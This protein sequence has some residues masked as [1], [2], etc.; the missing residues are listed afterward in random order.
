MAIGPCG[1][2]AGGSAS[3]VEERR[4]H[5]DDAGLIGG[6]IFFGGDDLF[7]CAAEMDSGGEGT[8]FCSPWN[9]GVERVVD[10]EGAAAVTK[11]LEPPPI[12]W[13][14]FVGGNGNQLARGDVGQ[15]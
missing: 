2:M 15:D 1:V 8:V 13:R 6:E 14:Q 9:W 5:K 3:A 10:F 4:L 11:A 12:R 7:D